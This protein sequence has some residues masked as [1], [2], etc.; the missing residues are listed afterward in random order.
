MH[1][2]KS[3]T[4]KWFGLWVPVGNFKFTGGEPEIFTRKG[5]SGKDVHFNFCKDCGTNL[6]AEI[7][8][9]KFYTVAAATVSD[10]DKYFPKM[11]IYTS[12]APKWAV[13]P[14]GVPK[15]DDLP[16]KFK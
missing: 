16:A 5:S 2:E 1:A 10:N 7:T 15:F 11:A 6:C 4:D 9:G 13:F 14:E 12:L 8:V 3:L